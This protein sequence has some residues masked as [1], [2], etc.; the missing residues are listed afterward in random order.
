MVLQSVRTVCASSTESNASTESTSSRT[1]EPN[2]STNGHGEPGSMKLRPA[3][4]ERAHASCI[5]PCDRG[6]LVGG[7]ASPC[8]HPQGRSS[9][10]GDRSRS[11]ARLESWR[12]ALNAAAVNQMAFC[13]A[14]GVHRTGM[15]KTVW[16]WNDLRWLAC[17]ELSRPG[18]G[19]ARHDQ[20]D[21]R[22][23]LRDRQHARKPRSSESDLLI[24]RSAKP[25]RSTSCARVQARRL[26][27][28]VRLRPS[29]FGRPLA[30]R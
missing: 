2:D 11:E 19:L 15:P 26:C 25:V 16:Q 12:K 1:R 14:E 6:Q 8:L 23:V 28:C 21:P 22:S 4:F 30:G 7:G 9:G 13:S 18:S 20:L 3:A 5:D 29:V 24:S 10:S 27:R 17:P